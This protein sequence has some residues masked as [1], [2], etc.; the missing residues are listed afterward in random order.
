M[1][2]KVTTLDAIRQDLL[3]VSNAATFISSTFYELYCRMD[4]PYIKIIL[5]A[6]KAALEQLTFSTAKA[7][8]QLKEYCQE[9][10]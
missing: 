7:A 4:N 3:E 1:K 10:K 6:E 2:A 5:N 8:Q 9:H